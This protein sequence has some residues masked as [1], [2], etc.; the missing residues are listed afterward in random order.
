[1]DFRP[2][3]EQL[4]LRDAVRAFLRDDPAVRSRSVREDGW[5][6][7]YDPEFSRR[8]GARGWIGLTWPRRYGG[9]E[10]SYLDRLIVTEELLLAGAPVA[11]HWF[12]DRQIGPALLAHG[13]ET[14]RAELLPRIARGELCF[15]VGMSE[16]NAGSDLA[17]LETRAE[18]RGD[19]FVIRG[20]KTWTSFAAHA[21]YCYLVARTDPEARPHRG[22]SE[23][24]VPMDVPGIEVR[25]IRDMVGETHFAELFFDDVRVPRAQLIGELHRGWYQI[26]QQLDYERSGI[27]RLISNAPLWNEFKTWARDEGL[28]RD[29]VL[30]DEMAQIEI[31]RFAGRQL[32]YRVAS[33][34]S[35]GQVPGREAAAAKA[36]CTEIEQRVARVVAAALGPAGL[37]EAGAPGAPLAGRA[38]RN[39]LYA[40]AYTIQ[41]G[42]NNILRNI[43]A[44]RALGLPLS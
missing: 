19:E 43:V 25:P 33:A 35:A 9:A 23:I 37:L 30:R 39:L 1:M 14:Q 28:T 15:C 36:I 13:S 21:D 27:E 7:G 11:A 41:G 10:R 20:Q 38:A 29:P 8:L 5:I 16:P 31:A 17:A 18:L 2:T 40:P 32:I 4:E 6:I 24:L 22:I 12:G 42:T 44:S 26:M 3:P 34:L